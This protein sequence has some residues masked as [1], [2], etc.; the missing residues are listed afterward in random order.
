MLN[1]PMIYTSPVYGMYNY[2]NTI[3]FLNFLDKN[4]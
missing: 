1:Q 3:R 4:D 2:D